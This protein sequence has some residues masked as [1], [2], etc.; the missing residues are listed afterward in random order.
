MVHIVLQILVK[1][2][3][4]R[5]TTNTNHR[6]SSLIAEKKKSETMKKQT[7]KKATEVRTLNTAGKSKRKNLDGEPRLFSSPSSHT[8]APNKKRS[9][10]VPLDGQRQRWP[11]HHLHSSHSPAFPLKNQSF[12]L[13]AICER[14]STTLIFSI[15]I[16]GSSETNNNK[17]MAGTFRFVATAHC[18]SRARFSFQRE[19]NNN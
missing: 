9:P 11:R 16:G 19:T 8:C 2:L 4:R 13:L 14:H 3:S 10:L 6:H 12:I 17:K 18:S 7:N 15:S 5:A 1:E